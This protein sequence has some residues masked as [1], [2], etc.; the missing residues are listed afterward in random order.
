M[1]LQWLCA[2]HH[3]RK[4][5]REAAAALAAERARNA[6]RKRKHPGLID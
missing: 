5:Q 6:P 1:N 4:T 2:W 3:K